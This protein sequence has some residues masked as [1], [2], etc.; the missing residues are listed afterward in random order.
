M[1]TPEVLPHTRARIFILSDIHDGSPD[2]FSAYLTYNPVLQRLLH[3]F[4]RLGTR[5]V[6]SK[7]GVSDSLPGLAATL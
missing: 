6:V 3:L 7:R 4:A 1:R 5:L 2:I